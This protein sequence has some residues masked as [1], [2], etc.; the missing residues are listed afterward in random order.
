MPVV[1]E[2]VPVTDAAFSG[3][4]K[5]QLVCASLFPHPLSDRNFVLLVVAASLGDT[6]AAPDGAGDVVLSAG[7]A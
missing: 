2:V 6:A 7:R 4:I 5:D 1:L 3:I